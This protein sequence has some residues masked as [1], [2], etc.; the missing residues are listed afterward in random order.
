MIRFFSWDIRFL[1]WE[2]FLLAI[3]MWFAWRRWGRAPGMTGV[4][5]KALLVV[6]LLAIT[7]PQINL[8]GQGI[9][10]IVVAD[11][12]R[13]L[14][15]DADARIRE[16][17][18]N[19]QKNRRQGDRV[20]IVAFGTKPAVESVLSSESQFGGWTKEI[21]PD[22][23]DLNEALHEALNLVQHNRPAR[24][25][26][27]SDGE[28]NGAS[29]S[30]AARRANDLGVPIDFREFPRPRTGDVA[31]DSLQLPE[32]VAPRE[33]FQYL[34]WV[35]S[36][37]EAT[38]KVTVFRD[39]EPIASDK[40]ERAFVSGL[41]RLLF[42]DL[43]EDGG[44]HNYEVRVD[45]P[46]D[47]LVE[48]N[49]GAGVVRVDAGPRLLVLNSDGQED[50]LVRA[51]RAGRIP[52]DV[53]AS[54]EHPL[55]SDTLD[56]YRTVV[57]E[58]VLAADLGR[59]KMERLA[60]F[61]EDLGGGLLVTGGERSFGNGGYFKS[62]LDEVLPVS[63]EMREEH[64][65]TRLAMAISLDRSGS[66][67][68]MVKGGKAKMDLANLGT[69]E[70]IKM[71]SP[72]D[73]VAVIAV[74]SSP[75]V[76]QKLTP[77]DDPAAIAAKVTKIR[78]EGGGIFVYEALVAAGKQLMDSDQSTKHIILFSDAND[79]EEP[80]DYKKLL[81]QFEKAGITTSVIG[82]GTAHD[83]DSKLLEDIAKLGHGNIMFT[84]DP[85]ELPRLFTQDTMS[86]ARSSFIKRDSEKQP[87]GIPGQVIP[88][89][90]LMGEFAAGAFP[91]VDGYNLSYLKPDATLGVVSQDEYAAPWSAFWYRGLGRVA[92]I[93]PEVDG[94]YSGAFGQW[95][96]YS[97][98]LITHA[99]WLLGGESPDDVYL[100]MERDGQDAV[101][102]V[103]LDP[104][105]PG[106]VTGDSPT[107]SIL[108]P[109]EEREQVLDLPFQWTGPN[110]LQA[111]FKL[112]RT[113]TYR[114]L[115]KMGGRNIVR[116]P[117]IT[118]PYSPEFMPRVGLPEGRKVLGAI[119]D[120]TGGRERLDVLEALTDRP[121]SARM[122][123]LVPWLL[124]LAI[125]L[126]LLEIAGRRLSLWSKLSEAVEALVPAGER[127]AVAGAGARAG[128][129]QRIGARWASLT[130]RRA[131]RPQAT[132]KG[133][134][135]VASHGAGSEAPP[136][137]AV[138]APPA[139]AAKSA[140]KIFEQAKRR[141]RKRLNE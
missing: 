103:E 124:M 25:I 122:T 90:Q 130:A 65:K 29:P 2:L 6:L 38:G 17:I 100:K 30:S 141:A 92:A 7:A 86:V 63:M 54:K 48:N 102:T 87:A 72:G 77:V 43:L 126:L 82:L 83:S 15:A 114:T 3:P 121:R 32:T 96:E 79:S 135:A 76:I 18:E 66:M 94:P 108:P 22:G 117:A 109:S 132:A 41:N 129:R 120:L 91:N 11:R 106:K 33:P 61:V 24:L 45:V 46:D 8:G 13:S 116:G 27:F 136:A 97:D 59:V 95:E 50:N 112:A 73:S 1:F 101:V 99:R 139:P 137:Q 20:G 51:L 34:V 131:A 78:S 47:P 14:P 56:R 119:G 16:L 57:I 75:H 128:W 60:Q 69:A 28:A 133:V 118:L 31:V 85:E 127:V 64:R 35:Y 67:A 44:L 111:R 134:T 9:D 53:A 37:R 140:E 12:S 138:P 81:A 89:A 49:R 125:V 70:A 10:I 52:V 4:L 88:S 107:L 23:S 104:D 80:G 19:L 113:G 36:A 123:S 84:E 26:V 5:R 68:V 71:L 40:T 105:R 21:L 42:R 55:S 39:G 115:V 62:P 110:S 98:F 58:N 74:D 93:T